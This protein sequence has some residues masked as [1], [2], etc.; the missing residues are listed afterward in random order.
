[1]GELEEVKKAQRMGI[2]R[3]ISIIES[4]EAAVFDSATFTKVRGIRNYY[5]KLSHFFHSSEG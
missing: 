3:A 5:F 2:K 4:L 1:M